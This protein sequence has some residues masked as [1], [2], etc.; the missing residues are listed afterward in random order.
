M[1][2]EISLSQQI[3]VRNGNF[4]FPGPS[5]K[6]G[7]SNL[8]VDQT[9][10]SGAVPGTISAVTIGQGTLVDLST[11]DITAGGWVIFQNLD[12]TNYVKFGPDN[13]AGN[14]VL[15][16]EMLPGEYAG[17]FRGSRTQQKLRFLADTGACDV[18]VLAFSK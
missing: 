14:I 3:S 9:K 7:S 16:G 6:F 15:M 17:P 8:L 2:Q 10:A 11:L 18:L 12:L 13:G 4:N 1:A 5:G